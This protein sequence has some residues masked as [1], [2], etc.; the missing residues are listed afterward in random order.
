MAKVD[1]KDAEGKVATVDRVPGDGYSTYTVVFTYKVDGHW[2]GGTFTS[3]QEYNVGDSVAL[4]YDPNDPDRN[5]LGD[6]EDD[7]KQWK[8]WAALAVSFLLYLLIKFL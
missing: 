1:W 5:D 4:R 2:C 8:I 3:N 7:R 6:K